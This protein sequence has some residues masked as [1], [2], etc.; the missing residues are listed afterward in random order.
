MLTLAERLWWVAVIV[1]PS[2]LLTN[3]RGVLLASAVGVWLSV[4]RSLQ[5]LL[6]FSSLLL[7][8][9]WWWLGWPLGDLESVRQRFMLWQDALSQLS[10]WGNGSYDF[11]NVVNREQ[12]LHNDWLQL[13]YELGIVGLAPLVLFYLAAERGAVPFIFALLVLGSFSFPLHS[14]ASAWMAAFGVGYHLCRRADDRRVVLRQRL[15]RPQL[16]RSENRA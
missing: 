2:I 12:H 1:S 6:A 5:W 11:S 15:E 8:I 13:I 16:R 3:S 10:L 7:V 4:S 14:P 9:G